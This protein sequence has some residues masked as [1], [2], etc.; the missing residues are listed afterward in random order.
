VGYHV[1]PE[2]IVGSGHAV[3]KKNWVFHLIFVFFSVSFFESKSM[4]MQGGCGRLVAHP[5]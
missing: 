3:V 2:K 1:S 5:G 4:E